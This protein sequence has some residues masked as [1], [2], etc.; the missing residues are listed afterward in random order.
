MCIT[1]IDFIYLISKYRDR[2][3]SIINKFKKFLFHCIVY[4]KHLTLI[5]RIANISYEYHAH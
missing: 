3:T 1:H 2:L 4:D 5:A